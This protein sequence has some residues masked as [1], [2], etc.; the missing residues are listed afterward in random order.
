M[1]EASFKRIEYPL[2]INDFFEDPA[3]ISLKL[4]KV[5]RENIK[6]IY[7]K[8]EPSATN[9][10]L[11]LYSEYFLKPFEIS[12][13]KAAE[14]SALE[15]LEPLGAYVLPTINSISMSSSKDLIQRNLADY[16]I[17]AYDSSWHASSAH[18]NI[19]YFV[20]NVGYFYINYATK[21]GGSGS[22]PLVLLGRIEEIDVEIIG[23]EHEADVALKLAEALNGERRLLM[24]DE[25]LNLIYTVRWSKEKRR[26]YAS[27]LFRTLLKIIEKGVCPVSVFYTKASDVARTLSHLTAQPLPQMQDKQLFNA[28]LTNGSRS[29]LF[30]VRNLVL[31]ELGF[32]LVCF[33]LKIGEGNV[34]R[35]ELPA[36]ALKAFENVVN[37][38]HLAVYLQSLISNGY[39]YCLLRAHE[40]AT[41][42]R[43]IIDEVEDSLSQALGIPSEHLRSRKWFSKQYSIA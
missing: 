14:S 28:F 10:V 39:P 29:Q 16:G 31:E 15:P 23:K 35:I 7:H 17:A 4:I 18:F 19:D 43:E 37:N 21:R 11:E 5:I 27:A 38:V 3:F 12:H 2:V 13:Y 40:V 36:E 24:L 1:G 32:Q 20:H 33:Y 22:H 9:A 6:D 41:L 26:S 25:S 34:V 42:S 30:K 8:E